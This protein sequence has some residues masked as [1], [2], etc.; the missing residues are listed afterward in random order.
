MCLSVASIWEMSIKAGLGKLHLTIPIAELIAMQERE[1]ELTVLDVR[2][3]HALAVQLLPNHHRDPF[4]RML[5][6]QCRIEGLE[7]VS[8]DAVLDKYGVRRMW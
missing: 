6:A 1:N 7:L 2:Q 8:A 4:D 3:E 5:I